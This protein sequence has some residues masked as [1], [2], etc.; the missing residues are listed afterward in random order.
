MAVV[1]VYTAS[2]TGVVGSQLR[3]YAAGLQGTTPI[4][5]KLRIYRAQLSGV[6]A[7]VV[8]PLESRTVEPETT[9]SYTALLVEG[10]S[11]G[12][13]QWRVVSGDA[14]L[15]TS[16]NTASFTAPS[17]M[18]QASGDVV[19]GVRATHNGITSSEV[20][21]TV[22]VRPQVRWRY[23]GTGWSGRTQTPVL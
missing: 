12:T 10:A 17:T 9:V 23:T 22:T 3:I 20:F 1:R 13:W 2:L 6:Q 7:V 8:Q 19:L 21:V 16:A 4:T 5:P 11:S 14:T 18:P 15:T